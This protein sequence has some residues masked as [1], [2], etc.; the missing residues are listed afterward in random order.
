MTSA[1]P[2]V[3]KIYKDQAAAIADRQ[4]PGR[5]HLNWLNAEFSDR[6]L[7]HAY[8]DFIERY[9]W[10][11]EY[12]VQLAAMALY[13]F[14]GI[15]DVLA[16]GSYTLEFLAIRFSVALFIIIYLLAV[17]ARP[18]MRRHVGLNSIAGLAICSIAILFMVYRM[19]VEGSP[20]YI[21]GVQ[22]CM[23]LSAC[24]MRVRVVH[25][26]P[27]YIFIGVAYIIS[28]ALK[29][30]VPLS[31]Y[32][33]A[34]FFMWSTVIVI[35]MANYVQEARS[36]IMWLKNVESERD[37]TKISE[38]LL[39]ATAA[40][41][42]K[43]SFLS[44]LTHE[45]KT[46]L[47]QIIGFTELLK[48]EVA[49]SGNTASVDASEYVI[50]AAN[51]MLARVNQMLRYSAVSAGTLE[52]VI[53]K[54]SSSELIEDLKS[55]FTEETERKG[56]TL[57]VSGV[58]PMDLHIDSHHTVYALSCI[59][60]NAIQASPDGATVRIV[61]DPIDDDFFRLLIIDSGKGISNEII[62]SISRPFAQGNSPLTRQNEGLGL[63]LAIATKIFETQNGKLRI[64]SSEGTGTI[65]TVILPIAATTSEATN[66]EGDELVA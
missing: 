15:L 17:G 10:R 33:S 30:D 4:L 45:L 14:Y 18:F 58:K 49:K 1:S 24:I 64:K 11:R 12:K 48:S 40:D 65:V 47:H 66:V 51:K 52:F 53:E 54:Y 41:K 5:K 27:T 35:S 3:S 26:V 6:Q 37:A 7:E 50:D 9:A 2:L 23:I 63:G 8:G 16:V 46:P 13:M 28:L 34:I 31:D 57:D 42:S 25:A 21:M 43:A 39:S 60:D 36:R 22:F 20:P 38:L 44:V 55:L 56:L 29:G 19:P 61:G 32:A 62:E 59:V